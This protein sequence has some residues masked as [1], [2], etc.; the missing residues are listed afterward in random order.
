MLFRI[1]KHSVD[2][3]SVVVANCDKVD[4]LVTSPS[5]DTKSV[6]AFL[7]SL[8]RKASKE[9]RQFLDQMVLHVPARAHNDDRPEALRLGVF[10]DSILLCGLLDFLL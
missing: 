2:K 10:P 1:E 7:V 5:W 8:E 4:M 3:I 6:V 9:R